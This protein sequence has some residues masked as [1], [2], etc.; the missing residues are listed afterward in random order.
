MEN[1]GVEKL[2][3]NG[4]KKKIEIYSLTQHINIEFSFRFIVTQGMWK[5]RM[6][7]KENNPHHE[8]ERLTDQSE[9]D[10]ANQFSTNI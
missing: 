1:Y 9:R 6:F 10:T 7:Q 2:K 5:K 4:L 8:N 3:K